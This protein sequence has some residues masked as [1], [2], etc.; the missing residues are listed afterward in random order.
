MEY[1]PDEEVLKKIAETI[2]VQMSEEFEL[3][4]KTGITM[5]SAI[6]SCHDYNIVMG[7]KDEDRHVD[8]YADSQTPD[9]LAGAMIDAAAEIAMSASETLQIPFED[10]LEFIYVIRMD[11]EK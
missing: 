2:N 6:S 5:A 10:I 11:K 9:V 7:R 4:L 1:K 8:V 3:A